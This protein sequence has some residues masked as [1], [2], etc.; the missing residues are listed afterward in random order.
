MSHST[1]VPDRRLDAIRIQRDVEL[2]ETEL[3][4]ARAK[5]INRNLTTCQYNPDIA[6]SRTTRL[7][8][9][10]EGRRQIIELVVT[11]IEYA[12]IVV[13]AELSQRICIVINDIREFP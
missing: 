4:C 7:V 11:S 9:N 2:A 6:A 10:V 8:H 3:F 12:K 5:S 1:F 13:N